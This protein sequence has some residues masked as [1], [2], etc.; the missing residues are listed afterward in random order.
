MEP[1][2]RISVIKTCTDMDVTAEQLQEANRIG[3]ELGLLE[4]PA[5]DSIGEELAVTQPWRN[6]SIISVRFLGGEKSVQERVEHYAHQW[7]QFANVKFKFV[8]QGATVARIV[9]APNGG[10]WSLLG[11][12]NLLHWFNQN[13]P[14]MNYGWLTPDTPDEEYS[15]VVIHEFGHLLGCIHEHQQ[16]AAGIPWDKEKA[17]AYYGSTNGWSRGAGGRAGLQPLQPAADT[18]LGV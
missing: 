12:G 2:E 15:R 11:A 7:E 8:D 14:T 13:A 6:G 3:A 18:I 16:P 17:Y 4:P 9:F 5:P 1:A 10:S